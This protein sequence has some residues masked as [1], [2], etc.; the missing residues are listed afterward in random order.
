ME[1]IDPKHSIKR[2]AVLAYLASTRKCCTSRLFDL[3]QPD[4]LELS[5]YSATIGFLRQLLGLCGYEVVPPPPGGGRPPP[6]MEALMDWML[7]DQ[8]PFASHGIRLSIFVLMPWLTCLSNVFA[9]LSTHRIWPCLSDGAGCC[10]LV[11]VPLY[12]GDERIRAHEKAQTSK[13]LFSI[14]LSFSFA[15]WVYHNNFMR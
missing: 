8:S 11:Q 2:D 4:H 7:N 1:L 3:R 10:V 5:K 12:Y 15:Q 6:E 14:S 9:Y 13:S